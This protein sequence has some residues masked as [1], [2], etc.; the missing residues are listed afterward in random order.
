MPRTILVVE[1]EVMLR[2]D[3]GQQLRKGGFAVF[4][5]DSA[6]EAV[7]LLQNTHIDAVVTDIRMP[8]DIDGSELVLWIRRR[9]PNV[10]IVVVSAH[11]DPSQDLPADVI[12]PKPIRIERLLQALRQILPPEERTNPG[13]R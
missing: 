8:G 6:D 4:E 11:V 13:R 3:L 12:L 10:K 2:L 7:S 9:V 1:D 5:A